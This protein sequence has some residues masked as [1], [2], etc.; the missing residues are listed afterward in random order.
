MLPVRL[1]RNP[2]SPRR[3]ARRPGSRADADRR[4]CVPGSTCRCARA[5]ARV[6]R[7]GS[8]R[9]PLPRV[10]W[11]R[12]DEFVEDEVER[13]LSVGQH[14]R[15]SDPGPFHAFAEFTDGDHV[16]D[17]K[18][19]SGFDRGGHTRCGALEP[20]DDRGGVEDQSHRSGC[21]A[22]SAALASSS[23]SAQPV[24]TLPSSA[25]LAS[26]ASTG[27]WVIDRSS[28]PV[29]LD[30]S[31]RPDRRLRRLPRRG[32]CGCAARGWRTPERPCTVL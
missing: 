11:W 13:R 6:L 23:S 31:D 3:P 30:W 27:D 2:I 1:P 10:R 18:L 17:R 4:R 20:A 16:N 25:A 19:V 12:S 21:A 9:R 7:R 26:R 15:C 22:R 5:I 29:D 32:A 8:R 24:S 14:V 28:R